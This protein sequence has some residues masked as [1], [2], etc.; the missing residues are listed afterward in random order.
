MDC[1]ME[2]IS[3]ERD[4]SIQ[5]LAAEKFS[6]EV[7]N[8]QLTDLARHAALRGVA[9]DVACLTPPFATPIVTPPGLN[10]PYGGRVGGGGT[11]TTPDGPKGA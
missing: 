8:A 3:H 4:S 9:R 11:G 2:A 7:T 10:R 6:H 5:Q 1:R